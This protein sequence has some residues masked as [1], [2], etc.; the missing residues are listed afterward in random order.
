MPDLRSQTPVFEPP[1]G[2]GAHSRSAVV[3]E[4][5]AVTAFGDPY[6]QLQFELE[7]IPMLTRAEQLGRELERGDVDTESAAGIEA[8]LWLQDEETRA[9]RAQRW[10]RVQAIE[11]RYRSSWGWLVPGGSEGIW[12]YADAVSA[13]VHGD[14]FASV[15]CC[16]AAAE[17]TL[18]A[19]LNLE[20]QLSGLERA[21]LG[22]LVQRAHD[23]QL[24]DDAA[25]THLLE[26]NDVRK[27]IAHLKPPT[28]PD[29][30]GERLRS[31]SSIGADYDESMEELLGGDAEHALECA[32]FALRGLGP[33]F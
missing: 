28:D 14:Y 25:R 22:P 20:E 1:S 11:A 6:G 12:L 21:G 32:N 4:G 27:P 29:S 18:A 31:R 9:R 19:R 23:L 10:I 17:R 30:V 16:H 8:I 15:V 13:Y 3:G 7:G 24:I 26:L 5:R 2:G 33:G